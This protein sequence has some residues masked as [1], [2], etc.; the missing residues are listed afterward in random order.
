S[1]VPG[2]TKITTSAAGGGIPVQSLHQYE[3]T[4]LAAVRTRR[5]LANA[6]AI[7]YD[8]TG[9]TY[10]SIW[11]SPNIFA[12]ALS[13][14]QM[15]DRIF[16]TSE[17]QR[18][19]VT[20]GIKYDGSDARRWG[21]VAPGSEPTVVDALDSNAGWTDSADGTTGTES[22]NTRDGAGA[23]SLD[24]DDTT[25]TTAFFSKASLGINFGTSLVAF[26]WVFLPAGTLQKLATSGT[27]L[28][29][30][31]GDAG[32]ANAD[33]HAFSVG[34]LVPGWNLLQ[35]ALDAPD[36]EDG[37]GATLSAVNTVRFTV[38]VHTTT[39]TFTDILFDNFYRV[40][41]GEP[42]ATVD[43]T[44]DDADPE[45]VGVF[46]YRVTFVTEYGVESNGGPA[47]NSVTATASAANVVLSY[48]G[49]PTAGNTITLDGRVYTFR[50]ALTPTAGE[51]LIAATAA[52]SYTNLESAIKGTGN[53]GT[54]Y[55]SA[56]SVHASVTASNDG[57]D[58]FTI[59]SK[60][61]GTG[62]NSIA[63]SETLAN[64]SFDGA[65]TT[66]STGRNGQEVDLTALPVSV[67][68]QVIARRIY[69]DSEGDNVYRFVDQVDNNI[70][71][72][73]S[74]VLPDASLGEATMPI[75]GDDQIDS[76]PPERMRAV[77]VHESRVFGISGDDPTII[78]ISDVDRPEIF[79]IVDQLSVDEELVGLRTHPFGL[80]LYGRTRALL[81]QGDGVQQPF[82]VDNLN[83]ELGANNFRCIVDVLGQNIVLR[84]EEVLHV[85]D[86]R[87]A[88]C[89][90]QGILDQ[91]KAATSSQLSSAFLAH[92]RD[93][94]RVIFFIGSAIWVYQYG[95]LGT[96]EITGD[97]PGV[98]PK[99]LRIGAWTTLSLPVTP[100]CAAL[101]EE[102]A[103]KPELWIGCSD[104]HIYQLQDASVTN[105][106]NGASTV[107]ITASLETH[108]VP[109]GPAPDRGKVGAGDAETGRGEPRYLEVNSESGSGITWAAVVTILS[110]ADGA[111]LAT[112]SFS[113]ACPAGK[114][115]VTV[116]VPMAGT[117]GSWARVSL[118]NAANSVDGTIRNLR[119]Y[120]I[121]RA[122]RRGP[123]TT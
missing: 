3:F 23:I 102:S 49:Q 76:S 4:S 116:P 7:L 51:V 100:V 37:T 25:T 117:I 89:I 112:S 78:L 71:T 120:Y 16:L 84:D 33:R 114:S 98:A 41:L 19:L 119:L 93:R 44:P 66:L 73:Y 70:T 91:F 38:N 85:A 22:T 86:P 26:V 74:D 123:R 82:R 6:G 13:S 24:K 109:L 20:G 68:P 46:T 10:T 110:E 56:T 95:T 54:D 104:G 27:A 72:T 65:A 55:A 9:G 115:V 77:V 69:R 60:T 15:H 30:R 64:A 48:T 12:E 58:D 17:N 79:R 107:A 62:G 83:T 35:L 8:V 63:V 118:T 50:A 90:N 5:Q 2:S 99:D 105:Y 81:L 97:G 28:E 32:L 108:A 96:Q 42:T 103:D 29:V 67:D 75:A 39:V 80:I 53:P 101:V 106:A 14:C 122:S 88:W 21:V 40:D 34:E 113:L 57:V 11:S 47:S 111:T 92:D 43:T 31:F 121:G 45:A 59:T 61:Q 94:F 1:K 36:T 52:L 87:D 18:K